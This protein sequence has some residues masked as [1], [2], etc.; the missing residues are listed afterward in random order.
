MPRQ[1]LTF[2][3]RLRLLV[4]S[5]ASLTDIHMAGVLVCFGLWMLNLGNVH[6]FGSIL[7]DLS[8]MAPI[9][10]WG[11]WMLAIA[12]GIITTA[13]MRRDSSLALCH[14]CSFFIWTAIAW[15]Y[16][17]SSNSGPKPGIGAV[18]PIHAIIS[19]MRSLQI[20]TPR[21]E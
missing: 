18:A 9:W 1:V 2:L 10:A 16:F 14:L 12:V 21:S 8:S 15:L 6:R 19:F 20:P 13:M 3:H 5:R 17:N 11:V 4:A 7:N